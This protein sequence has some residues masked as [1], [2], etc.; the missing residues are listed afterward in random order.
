MR[1]SV[2]ELAIMGTCSMLL[3]GAVGAACKADS[4]EN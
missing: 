3:I 2:A 4:M 1:P